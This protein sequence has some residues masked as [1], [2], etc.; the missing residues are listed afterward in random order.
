MSFEKSCGYFILMIIKDRL[1]P[2]KRYLDSFKSSSLVVYTTEEEQKLQ[3]WLDMRAA[4]KF[5]IIFDPHFSRGGGFLYQK[6]KTTGFG[7]L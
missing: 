3:E 6:G 7:Q 1:N 2:T 5:R 4:G